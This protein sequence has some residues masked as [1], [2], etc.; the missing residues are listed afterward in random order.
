[1]ATLQT[2]SP[3]WEAKAQAV[4][5][6]SLLPDLAYTPE[7]ARETDQLYERVKRVIP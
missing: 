1:M 4:L 3:E 5:P 7:V 6:P 2:G